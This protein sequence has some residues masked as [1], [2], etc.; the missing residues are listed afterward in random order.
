[1]TRLQA[2]TRA[3]DLLPCSR[4]NDLTHDK[5]D[6]FELYLWRLQSKLH[7]VTKDQAYEKLMEVLPVKN[8]TALH[9][10]E[11]EISRDE[12]ILGMSGVNQEVT[13]DSL[14]A[15]IPNA[16]LPAPRSLVKEMATAVLRVDRDKSNRLIGT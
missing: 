4:S 5:F 13:L 2:L 1:M 16:G 6:A 12:T 9:R 8:V 14:V 11:A 7:T 15:M 10:K 3:W